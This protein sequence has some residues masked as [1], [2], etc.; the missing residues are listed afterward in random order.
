ML[1]TAGFDIARSNDYAALVV[2]AI[3]ENRTY[4]VEF[5][6]QW[7][8][9]KDPNSPYYGIL[10]N[11]SKISNMQ[12]MVQYYQLYK[13]TK[14]G[15]DATGFGDS[16]PEA[17]RAKGIPNEAIKITSQWK[18]DAIQ[19]LKILV[20]EKRIKIPKEYSD[21]KTQMLEQMVIQGAPGTTGVAKYAH[22]SNKHDDLL[23]ALCLALMVARDK[24]LKGPTGI[25]VGTLG[26]GEQAPMPLMGED[27]LMEY[28]VKKGVNQVMIDRYI[29]YLIKACNIPEELAKWPGY[30]EMELAKALKQ[31][32]KEHRA[33]L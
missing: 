11:G 20:H 17:L 1:R 29:E 8:R 18:N 19:L 25:G 21:L 16:M 2:G 3:T 33:E 27:D 13:W 15:V 31:W 6:Y 9:V 5:A 23:W 4:V 10:I 26:A 14:M 22:P 12:G 28:C 7:P 24:L 32:E 30:A